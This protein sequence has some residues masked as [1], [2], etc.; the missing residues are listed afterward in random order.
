MKIFELLR[1]LFGGPKSIDAIVRPMNKIV[2]DLEAYT[3]KQTE[4]SD[5]HV[6]EASKL[7]ENAKIARSEAA[8]A[9]ALAGNY[10]TLISP[11]PAE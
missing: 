9:E 11:V 3:A 1:T 5:K 6:A 10:K 7:Q 4:R 8:A 2:R